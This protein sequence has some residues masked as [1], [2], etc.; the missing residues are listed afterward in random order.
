MGGKSFVRLL[1]VSLVV[2]SGVVG[3]TTKVQG[4][5]SVT[6]TGVVACAS[7]K[8]VEGT[9]VVSSAGGGGFAGWQYRPT[10]TSG[11]TTKYGYS[12]AS[13]R[14][15]VPTS[16]ASTVSINV[17]CGD[18]KC[19]PKASCSWDSDNKSAKSKTSTGEVAISAGRSGTV[20]L[21]VYSCGSGVCTSPPKGKLG[22]TTNTYSKGYCT[23]G[24][25]YLWNK[26]SGKYPGWGGDASLWYSRA[27]NSTWN[28][29]GTSTPMAH[30][31]IVWQGTNKDGSKFWKNHVGYVVSVDYSKNQMVYVDMNG[32][33]YTDV[34]A[35]KTTNF[36]RYDRKTCDLAARS[37]V[38]TR[39]GS[40][41]GDK[42]TGA[43]FILA[44]PGFE[45]SW[46]AGSYPSAGECAASA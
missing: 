20:V 30:A 36:G 45:W 19:D 40:S 32:G 17:G 7:G 25:A 4:A 29:K 8:Y 16:A 26:N 2:A 22:G 33:S 3:F 15:S 18:H 39:T 14:K 9:W 21:N 12:S 1:L 35:E 41:Y 23:C 10:S 6:V 13:Y 37:C 11:S 5:S 46:G 42:V 34:N 38:S 24:A 44:Q 43:Y 31:L 28:W 27:T